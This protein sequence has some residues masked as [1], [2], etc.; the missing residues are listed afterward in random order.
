M[1]R[2]WVLPD[3]RA[4]LWSVAELAEKRDDEL[5][6]PDSTDAYFSLAKE[7]EFEPLGLL[8]DEEPHPQSMLLHQGCRSFLLRRK[9][10]PILN[11]R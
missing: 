4:V 8:P 1:I 6:S 2:Y 5:A 7:L 10:G 11:V 9:C 3:G